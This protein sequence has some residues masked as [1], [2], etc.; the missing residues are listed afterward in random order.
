MDKTSR[1]TGDIFRR[2]KSPVLSCSL[3]IGPSVSS[4]TPSVRE[5]L[6]SVPNASDCRVT[7]DGLKLLALTVSVKIK[8]KSPELRSISKDA[9]LGRVVSTVRAET[10]SSEAVSVPWLAFPLMSAA[11][12]SERLMKVDWLDKPIPAVLML[13][14]S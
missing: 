10:W 7:R 13:F 14:R 2:L 12:S 4:S 1:A 3:S 6:L 5:K 11:V 9:M 8:V